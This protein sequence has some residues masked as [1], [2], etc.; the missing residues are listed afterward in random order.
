MSGRLLRG[1][2]RGIAI[3]IA[4]AAL[5]DPV[6]SIET[7]AGGV[8]DVAIRMTAADA[9]PIVREVT[10][11]QLPVRRFD[12]RE[13]VHHRLPCGPGERCVVLADGSVDAELPP[14]LDQPLSLNQGWQQRRP[15]RPPG[16]QW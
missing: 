7:R 16:V 5:V 3:A 14:D 9:A 1:I 2:L 13:V 11:R 10:P 12:I 6:L 15:Q 8:R 4:V